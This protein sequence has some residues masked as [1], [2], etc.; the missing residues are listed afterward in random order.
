MERDFFFGPKK[1]SLSIKCAYNQKFN[2]FYYFF[3]FFLV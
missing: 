3:Y 1:K 2:I